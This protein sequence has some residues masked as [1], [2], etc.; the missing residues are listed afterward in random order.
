MVVALAGFALRWNGIGGRTAFAIGLLGVVGAEL[1]LL[2]ISRSYITA[3]Q[4]RIIKLEMRVRCA[5]L[6]TPEQLGHLMRLGNKQIVA[7]RF[8]SDAEL[9]ALLDRTRRERLAPKDIKRAV[10][11]W[12]PDLDR[13]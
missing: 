3:L 8:A 2:F 1:A 9:P 10:K 5:S 7:L 6:L 12:A 4:D 11:N 13:T